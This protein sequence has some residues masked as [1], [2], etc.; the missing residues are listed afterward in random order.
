MGRGEE[1]EKVWE[2]RRK[3]WVWMLVL[4]CWVHFC[5]LAGNVG[6]PWRGLK[7]MTFLPL[8]RG[9]GGGVPLQ[10]GQSGSSLAPHSSHPALVWAPEL[11]WGWQGRVGTEIWREPEAEAGGRGQEGKRWGWRHAEGKRPKD[12]I[13]DGESERVLGL[14]KENPPVCVLVPDSGPSPLKMGGAPRGLPSNTQGMADQ[15]P[16]GSLHQSLESGDLVVKENATVP[17]AHCMSLWASCLNAGCLSL[18]IY[19]PGIIIRPF[20][21]GVMSFE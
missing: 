21:G 20:H 16:P 10:P 17:S 11:L 14:T 18:P 9:V 8:S 3:V 5:L 6:A 15:K 4:A 1:R 13:R 12:T 2:Y 19:K 7:I